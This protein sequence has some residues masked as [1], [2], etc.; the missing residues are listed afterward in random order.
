M[1]ERA[2]R[3]QQRIDLVV[4]PPA[5]PVRFESSVSA[6]VAEDRGVSAQTAVCVDE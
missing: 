4:A 6:M 3:Q 5:K 1:I 2:H